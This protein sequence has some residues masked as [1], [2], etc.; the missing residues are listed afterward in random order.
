M[1][2]CSVQTVREYYD[3]KTESILRRYGP[4]PRVHYHNGILE[5]AETGTPTE[6]RRLLAE[7]P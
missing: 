4:G 1:A 6:I 7:P 3:S 5:A 2:A